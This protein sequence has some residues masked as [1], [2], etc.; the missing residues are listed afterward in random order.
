MQPAN[1]GRTRARRRTA[2]ASN[3]RLAGSRTST[4]V[5]ARSRLGRA[6]LACCAAT[7]LAGLTAASASAV[8]VHLGSG[9]TV[10]YQ[11]VRGAAGAL[12]ASP[13][14]GTGKLLYHG[15]PV[16][17]SNTNYALYW[18][19][20]G[21][22]DYAAG[23]QTGID[24]YFEDLAHDS[25]GTQNVDSVATQ[26]TDSSAEAANYDSHFAGAIVDTDPYPANGCTAAPICL[27]DAQIQAEIKSFVNAHGLPADLDARVLPAGA[28]RRRIAASTRSARNARPGRARRRSAPTTATSPTAAA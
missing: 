17:P 20:S 6:L 12:A 18:A 13:F 28:A 11:P 21:S 15:G 26:Y 3:P 2:A 14:A 19:P 5:A 7:L 25:G 24:H 1:R 16:M 10:S 8:I 9:K 27:T 22:P 23:Y 4:T